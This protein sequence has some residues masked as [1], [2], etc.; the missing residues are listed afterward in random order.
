MHEHRI[1]HTRDSSQNIAA[2][3]WSSINT[4]LGGVQLGATV[5][6]NTTLQRQIINMEGNHWNQALKMSKCQ[7]QGFSILRAKMYHSTYPAVLLRL[8]SKHRQ[9]IKLTTSIW[10]PLVLENL[11]FLSLKHTILFACKYT[12]HHTMNRF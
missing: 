4:G 3:G 9:K 11:F 7:N 1:A 12:I 2:H 8:V 10:F 5:N 6:Q